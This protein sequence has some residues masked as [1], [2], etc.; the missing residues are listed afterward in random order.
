[1]FG[2]EI[3]RRK[4]LRP[5]RLRTTVRDRRRGDTLSWCV[6]A[7]GGFRDGWVSAKRAGEKGEKGE[8][9]RES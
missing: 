2:V 4:D 5:R 8:G 3:E 1:M 6:H 9:E 7:V